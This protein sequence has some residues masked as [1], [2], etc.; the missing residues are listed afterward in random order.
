MGSHIR[1]DLH[2]IITSTPPPHK[3]RAALCLLL[4]SPVADVMAKTGIRN[5]RSLVR[6]GD[7]SHAC[8]ADGSCKVR[9]IGSSRSG[10]TEASCFS[11]EFGRSCFGSV[12]GCRDCSQVCGYGSSNPRVGR[13]KR[14]GLEIVRRCVQFID[15]DCGR[16]IVRYDSTMDVNCPR[17]QGC[18]VTNV[19]DD[20]SR[21]TLDVI[22]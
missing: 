17:D 14:R 4:L 10:G 20:E 18:R 8:E 7:C 16:D 12:P 13:R 1:V 2:S 5:K 9:W 19:R 15:C 21:C 3:M 6:E 22:G 11:P